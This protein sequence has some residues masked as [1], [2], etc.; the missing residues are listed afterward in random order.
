M[1]DDDLNYDGDYYWSFLNRY[2][3]YCC[4]CYCYGDDVTLSYLWNFHYDAGACHSN[5]HLNLVISQVLWVS[6]VDDI[7]NLDSSSFRVN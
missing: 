7:C 1:N 4:Y 5:G 2:C 3:Y 6:F